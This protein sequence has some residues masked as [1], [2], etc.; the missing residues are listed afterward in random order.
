MTQYTD[1][2]TIVAILGLLRWRP[3]FSDTLN[4]QNDVRLG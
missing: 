4:P 3:D 1:S 2:T